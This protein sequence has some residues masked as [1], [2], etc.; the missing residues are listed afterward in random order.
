M[1]ERYLMIEPWEILQEKK[2]ESVVLGIALQQAGKVGQGLHV[3]VNVIRD[4][5]QILRRAFSESAVK[6]LQRREPVIESGSA[7]ELESLVTLKKKYSP[8]PAVFLALYPSPKMLPLL[9]NVAD[10]STVV[11][12]TEQNHSDHV[13]EWNAKHKP[14]GLKLP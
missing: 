8:G 1:V 7:I 9:E 12:F 2:G 5:D 4:S 13:M 3:C 14:K 10:G 11:V 6:K